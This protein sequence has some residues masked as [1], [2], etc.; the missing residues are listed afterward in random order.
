[1]KT[2]EFTIEVKKSLNF[3]T[4]T[5]GEHCILEDGDDLQECKRKVQARCRKLIYEQYKLDSV[6]R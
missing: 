5:V 1:M 6:R 3:Q 2:K 4:Y